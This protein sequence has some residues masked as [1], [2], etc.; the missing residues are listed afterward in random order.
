M[1]Y[2]H[3]VTEDGGLAARKWVIWFLAKDQL[4]NGEGIYSF[5]TKSLDT[6]HSHYYD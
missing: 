6:S 3:A 4:Q 2:Y 5:T 1:E